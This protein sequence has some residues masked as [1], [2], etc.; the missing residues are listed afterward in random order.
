M[1]GTPARRRILSG[2]MVFAAVAS[3]GAA[4]A[5]RGLWLDVPFVRQAPEGCGSA[6]IAMVMRYWR[7]DAPRLADQDLDPEQIQRLLYDPQ[8]GGIRARDMERYF[9][10]KGFQTFAFRGDWQDLEHHLAQGRPLI[11]CLR[12]GRLEHTLHYVVV[13][14]LDDAQGVVLVNDPADRKLRKIERTKFLDRWRAMDFWT[15]LALPRQSP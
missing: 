7:H 5:T 2:L 13:A 15:L 14:G 9:Q 8:A 3:F 6:C 11:V 12:E 4:A 10:Q 1:N